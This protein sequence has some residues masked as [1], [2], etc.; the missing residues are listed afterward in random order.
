M[1]TLSTNSKYLHMLNLS[2]QYPWLLIFTYY[3]PVNI[4]KYL[5]VTNIVVTGPT[6]VAIKRHRYCSLRYNIR[7]YLDVTLDQCLQYSWNLKSNVCWACDYNI[8]EFTIFTY[9]GPVTTISVTF[10]IIKRHRYCS[11]RYNIRK[12]LDVTDIVMTL[13]NT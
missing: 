7:K 8:R 10:N 2:L 1:T 11:L 9:V 13:K 3:G 12:Y 5:D 4:R 6:Y